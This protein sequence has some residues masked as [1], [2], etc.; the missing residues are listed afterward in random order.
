MIS[1][2][3]TTLTWP[4]VIPLALGLALL[5]II[6]TAVV[7]RK[8]PPARPT[9]E[10][11]IWIAN[12][13]YLEQLPSFAK[14][15]R[16]YRLLQ[17]SGIAVTVAALAAVSV[18][19]A[20]PFRTTTVDP[21]LANRDIV[22]CLDVSGSMIAYDQEIVDLFSTLTDN[23]QGERIALSVFNSTSRLVFPLTDDYALVKEQ[24]TQAKEALDPRVLTTTR[25]DVIDNYLYFT[26][27][28]NGSLNGWSSLIGDGL[29]NCALLFDEDPYQDE[30]R[31]RSIIFATDNDLQGEPIYTLQD[32]TNLALSRNIS[33]IGLYGA[34]GGD[35]QSE[36]EFRDIFLDADGLYFFSDDP[37]T[38]P[39]IVADIQAQQAV[40]IDAAPIITTTNLPGPYLWFLVALIAAFIVQRRITE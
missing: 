12:S 8:R 11:P 6:V 9:T 17:A 29:A 16:R 24:L 15:R 31:S 5:T 18:V 7:T 22:L 39:E 21:R 34:G 3:T 20:Q 13:D 23:F 14:E 4:W 32:A 33:L 38:I 37:D 36:Q 30:D 28:A 10:S 25:Q 2:H 27:G 1:T 26:A 40:A 35:A 19:T